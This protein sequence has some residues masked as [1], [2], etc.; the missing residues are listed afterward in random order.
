MVN[1]LPLCPDRNDPFPCLV[2]TTV[3]ASSVGRRPFRLRALYHSTLG[4][5]SLKMFETLTIIMKCTYLLLYTVGMYEVLH[6]SVL[7]S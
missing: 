4:S 1:Q 7:V 2:C 5:P 3:R 6:S